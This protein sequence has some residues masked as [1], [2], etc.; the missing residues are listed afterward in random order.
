MPFSPSGKRIT[1]CFL[2]FFNNSS[3]S[4]WNSICYEDDWLSVQSSVLFLTQVDVNPSLDMAESD[5]QNNVMRCRCKYDGA[6]VY[7]FGCHAGNMSFTK[8]SLFQYFP[9]WFCVRL[10]SSLL[11]FYQA[12]LTAL[13][14]R[15][16]S[17]TSVRSPTT[18]CELWETQI[19]WQNNCRTPHHTSTYMGRE[20]EW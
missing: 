20:G 9:D 16:C 12:T 17:T 2:S 11:C 13:R 6:R 18:S 8:F 4:K 3:V 7:M 1:L 5:F 19:C 10:L 15:T 14:R